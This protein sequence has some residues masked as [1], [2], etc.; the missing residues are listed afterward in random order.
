MA[1]SSSSARSSRDPLDVHLTVV[2]NFGDEP[3]E[4]IILIDDREIKMIGSVFRYR[5]K[6]TRFMTLSLLKAAMLQP[7]VA[8]KL[9]PGLSLLARKGKAGD[10]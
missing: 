8:K 6:V 1:D 2:V 3:D 10:G 7:K 5:D 4:K 9:L